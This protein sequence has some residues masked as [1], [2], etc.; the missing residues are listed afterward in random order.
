MSQPFLFFADRIFPS[1]RS[2]SRA[3]KPHNL[4]CHSETSTRELCD[5]KLMAAGNLKG[6]KSIGRCRR[7]ASCCYRRNRPLGSSFGVAMQILSCRHARVTSHPI[8]RCQLSC[9][10]S[11]SWELSSLSEILSIRALIVVSFFRV[12]RGLLPAPNSA[13]GLGV[14]LNCHGRPPVFE[15][16]CFLCCCCFPLRVCDA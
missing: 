12:R 6:G 11:P 1:W 2:S 5:L 4:T 14:R 10:S 9:S 8:L 15:S 16:C 7:R 13:A 3:D